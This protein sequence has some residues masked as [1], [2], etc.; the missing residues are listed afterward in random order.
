MNDQQNRPVTAP[1]TR[2]KKADFIRSHKQGR[3]LRAAN[4]PSTRTPRRTA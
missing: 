2:A 3:T 1:D 4:H